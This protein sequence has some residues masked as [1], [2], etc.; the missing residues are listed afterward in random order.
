MRLE[1]RYSGLVFRREIQQPFLRERVGVL[2]E[3]AAALRLFF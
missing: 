1:L 3:T 2:G